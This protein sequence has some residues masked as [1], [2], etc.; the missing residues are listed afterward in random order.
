MK[1]CSVWNRESF[2]FGRLSVARLGFGLGTGGLALVLDHCF[3]TWFHE[4]IL[5]SLCTCVSLIFLSCPFV[6][7][8]TEEYSFLRPKSIDLKNSPDRITIEGKKPY[9][10]VYSHFV[11]K[12]NLAFMRNWK[13]SM[14]AAF[15]GSSGFLLIRKC[16]K[17]I[18]EI[19][20]ENSLLN[21]GTYLLQNDYTYFWTDA[22]LLH[23]WEDSAWWWYNG[24]PLLSE[25]QRYVRWN[26]RKSAGGICTTLHW[27]S[28][29]RN[30]SKK[31][32]KK[33][34]P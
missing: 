9:L 27:N 1:W 28:C 4:R 3:P 14:I 19:L 29:L 12:Y 6:S 11:M 2:D 7:P 25:Y 8:S 22:E 15:D 32:P 13:I 24:E 30:S 26:P 20:P 5:F 34:I 31:N 18:P 33:A 17:A 23:C 21:Y 10:I 16:C